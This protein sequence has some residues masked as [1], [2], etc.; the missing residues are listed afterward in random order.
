MPNLKNKVV[1]ITGANRGQGKSITEHLD[2]LGAKI[3]VG[4]RNFQDAISVS[5]SL[6][7]KSI[8]IKLDITKE[9]DWKK[10]VNTI[11]E[12]FGQIDILVNNA[13]VYQRQS[14]L[15]STLEE[16][17]KLINVNQIGI[18][19]GMKNVANQMK[20]QQQGSIINTVSISSFSPINQ[21]SLYASTKAAVTTMSKAAA[22]EL[23]DYGIRVN[24]VHPGGVDTGMFSESK[25][26][27]S[28]YD[29][30]PLHRIGKSIDIAKAIAFFASDESSYCTGTE[31]V[32]DGGMTLGTDA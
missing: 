16:Y 25:G 6:T 26:G 3:A 11:L 1:L 29:S 28:F 21:S 15:E 5:Q 14:F 20:N 13:G 31:L 19:L 2:F 30:I 23:G 7:N 27:N 22:I 18:F 4:S 8:P 32:V 12:E 24:M 9:E 17:E 10:A